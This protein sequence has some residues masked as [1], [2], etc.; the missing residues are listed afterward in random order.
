L[1][2]QRKR[3]TEIVHVEHAIFADTTNISESIEFV[4][5][6]P[7]LVS[8]ILIL[9]ALI[10]DNIVSLAPETCRCAVWCLEAVSIIVGLAF[11]FHLGVPFQNVPNGNPGRSRHRAVS[12]IDQPTWYHGRAILTGTMEAAI[13]ALTNKKVDK[14]F[15]F[16]GIDK[17][18]NKR[19]GPLITELSGI[20]L[21]RSHAR[22]FGSHICN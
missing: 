4:A 22:R 21:K 16:F 5:F 19:I 2:L 17:S 3:D 8:K 15:K 11:S 12:V 6:V 1:D 14:L 9:V 20:W 18:C 7:P 13:H 10:F